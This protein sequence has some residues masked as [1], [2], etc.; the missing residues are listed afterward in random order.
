VSYRCKIS[1]TP[2][3]PVR[4]IRTFIAK[5][6]NF[7]ELICSSYQSI[8]LA[9]LYYKKICWKKINTYFLK[10]N[11]KDSNFTFSF[12]VLIHSHYMMCG[13][14]TSWILMENMMSFEEWRWRTNGKERMCMNQ[15]E[16]KRLSHFSPPSRVIH[17]ESTF[18]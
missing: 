16:R 6:K 4:N 11:Q 14:S 18:L 9:C 17:K 8:C 12:P 2:S 5:F 7:H 13:E 15:H 1:Q 3:P 10:L